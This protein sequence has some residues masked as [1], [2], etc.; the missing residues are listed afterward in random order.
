[1]GTLTVYPASTPG[2]V[3]AVVGLLKQRIDWLRRRGVD[4]WSSWRGWDEKIE[5]GVS[6]GSV[7]LL[8]DQDEPVGTVTVE[9]TPDR[10]FW[11][12]DEAADPAMYLS[13]LATR[14]DRAGA[15][16]GALLLDWAGE[17]AYRRGCRYVRLDAWKTNGRLHAYYRQRG[18]S[19]VRMSDAAHR[20]SGALFQRP[21]RRM[22]RDAAGRVYQVPELRTLNVEHLAG[23]SGEAGGPDHGNFF[24]G[25]THA[26]GLY[27]VVECVSPRPR[28]AV[29]LD[30][31]RYRVTRQSDR[32]VLT[33]QDGGRGVE[34]EGPVVAA[35]WPL[36]PGMDYVLSHDGEHPACRMVIVEVPA[37]TP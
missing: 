26:G 25:H 24:P 17:H 10:D 2:D 18:W 30:W 14:P 20:R 35:D 8:A 33:S 13:K 15:E 7:W 37:P 11:T 23:G 36:E 5:A 9:D 16:L 19:F 3:D 32:W 1:M 29:Y 31:L 34:V 21:A 28:P 27:V 4:Q 12:S 6:A 22:G